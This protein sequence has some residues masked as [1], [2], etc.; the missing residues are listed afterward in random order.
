MSAR[1][2]S[3]LPGRIGFFFRSIRFRL[4]LWFSAILALVLIAFSA[5][6]YLNQSRDILGESEF[7]LERKMAALEL[8][9]TVS[10]SGILVPSGVLQDTDGC[11]PATVRFLRR[12]PSV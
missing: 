1:A 5:F 8:T 4:V 10:P 3:T 6:I 7:R 12:K 11:W 2:R 9:L